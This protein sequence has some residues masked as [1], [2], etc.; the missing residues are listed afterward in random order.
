[1]LVNYN[2]TMTTHLSDKQSPNS[3]ILMSDVDFQGLE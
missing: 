3:I 2:N 1:M